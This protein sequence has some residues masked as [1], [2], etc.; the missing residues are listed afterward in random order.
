MDRK[1]CTNIAQMVENG[2]YGRK[3]QKW[4]RL[5]EM[6]KITRISSFFQKW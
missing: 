3:Y 6:V 5:E 4:Y 1:K 2:S